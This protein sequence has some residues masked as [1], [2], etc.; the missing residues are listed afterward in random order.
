MSAFEMWTEEW[1]RNVPAPIGI[2]AIQ[3]HSSQVGVTVEDERALA[4]PRGLVKCIF[5]ATQAKNVQSIL[6]LGLLPGG[7]AGTA[8]RNQCF[9]SMEDW[10]RYPTGYKAERKPF[11]H[12]R[13]EPYFPRREA[14]VIVAVSL[15]A[16]LDAGLHPQ[17]SQT[18]A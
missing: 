10:R 9:F 1:W 6:R 2:K 18:L 15:N 4:I 16:L 7:P 11:N 17:L 3:G 13:R 5:H 8:R 12:V 14:E